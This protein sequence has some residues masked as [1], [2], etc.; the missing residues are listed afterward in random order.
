M[1]DSPITYLK[2]RFTKPLKNK[3]TSDIDITGFLYA[4]KEIKNRALTR[5]NGNGVAQYILPILELR[6]AMRKSNQPFPEEWEPQEAIIGRAAIIAVDAVPADDAANPPVAA[7]P[8]QPAQAAVA[9]RPAR[10]VPTLPVSRPTA[11]SKYGNVNVTA[12]MLS[13]LQDEQATWQ[14]CND[15][16]TA[17]MEDVLNALPLSLRNRLEADELEP[18]YAMTMRRLLEILDNT[19][20]INTSISAAQLRDNFMQPATDLNSQSDIANYVKTVRDGCESMPAEFRMTFHQCLDKTIYPVIA[21]QLSSNPMLAKCIDQLSA[22]EPNLA[23]MSWDRLLAVLERHFEA[24]H[25]RLMR[26]NP[27]YSAAATATA[28]SVTAGP[29]RSRGGTLHGKLRP[30][31]TDQPSNNSDC[32]FCTMVGYA[33]QHLKKDCKTLRRFQQSEADSKAEYNASRAS[34]PPAPKPDKTDT[35]AKVKPQV[36]KATAAACGGNESVQSDSD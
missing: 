18:F 1:D 22:D 36:R 14:C 4:R 12:A 32:E 7:Q 2:N 16:I 10:P 24:F 20:S 13:V 27:S 29:Q 11:R 26:D 6:E 15:M 21:E 9:A 3:I 30:T 8:A 19:F 28:S 33:R 23:L 34:R 17:L 25:N 35:R 5:Y 31:R